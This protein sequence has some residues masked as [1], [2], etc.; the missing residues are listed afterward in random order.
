[1]CKAL[2]THLSSSSVPRKVQEVLSDS[3]WKEDI[4]E[5]MNPCIRMKCGILLIYPKENPMVCK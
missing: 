3:K 5:E 1:M 4:N 2:I